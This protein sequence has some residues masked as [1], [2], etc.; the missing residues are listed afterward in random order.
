[1]VREEQKVVVNSVREVWQLSWASTP[2]P[3]CEPSEVSLTCPCEGFAYGES[4]KLHLIRLRSGVAFDQL[5]L[6]R[7]FTEEFGNSGV[8][9][10]QLREPDRDRDF[11][12][13]LQ[14]NFQEIV[15]K[16]PAVQVM[17]FADYDHDG[18]QTEFYL[19]TEVAPCGKSKGL[20]IG[21]SAKN[22]RLHAFGAASRPAEPLFLFKREWEALRKA[23]GPVEVVDWPCGDHGAD[24]QIVLRLQWTTDGVKGTSREFECGPDLKPGKLIREGPL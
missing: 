19:Q 1:M 7:F 4:G 9:M 5:D 14:D 6:S 17:H 24:T 13:A 23:S 3:F 22:P 21:V 15:S 16:R 2:K 10:I 18:G 20:V 12:F 8:A 11:D